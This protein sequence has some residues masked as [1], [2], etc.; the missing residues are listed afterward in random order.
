MVRGSGLGSGLGFP[1]VV[2]GEAHLGAVMSLLVPDR[3]FGCH[4]QTLCQREG[5]TVPK[6]VQVC[7]DAVEKR[8]MLCCQSKVQPS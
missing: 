1:A 3:V 5:T 8:G 7:L 6:F 4:L 2:R